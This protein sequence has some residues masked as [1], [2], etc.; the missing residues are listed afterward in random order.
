[1]T[2]YRRGAMESDK[3]FCLPWMVDP[4]G[5]FSRTRGTTR[6]GTLTIHSLDEMLV[7]MRSISRAIRRHEDEP[8]RRSEEA[9]DLAERFEALD[10][11]LSSGQRELP[12]SWA[13]APP[14]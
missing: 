11:W 10:D 12:K 3:L 14:G 7:K 2:T 4:D 13:A 1:M 6:T 8:Q 5:T 9:L